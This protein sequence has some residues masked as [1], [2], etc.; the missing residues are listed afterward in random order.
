MWEQMWDINT[1]LFT[2]ETLALQLP[3]LWT[4]VDKSGLK[5]GLLDLILWFSY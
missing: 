3:H 2:E 5:S 4:T 1:A